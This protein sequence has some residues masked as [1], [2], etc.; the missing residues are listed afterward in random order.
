MK[1]YET[2]KNAFMVLGQAK[3]GMTALDINVTKWIINL[4]NQLSW[5]NIAR[6]FE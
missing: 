6:K 2:L 5:R 1:P 3:I 4:I